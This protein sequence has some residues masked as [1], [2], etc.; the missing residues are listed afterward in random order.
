MI[1]TIIG[2]LIGGIFI[3]ALARLALPGKQKIGFLWTMLLGAAGSILGSWI[4]YALGYEGN[5]GFKWI[6]FIVGIA[7]A[8]GL[9]LAYMAIK[10][11]GTRT[12]VKK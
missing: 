3:G 5:G 4:C 9:I 6:P 8:A 12:D 11:Q 1:G 10:G 2:A 7:V